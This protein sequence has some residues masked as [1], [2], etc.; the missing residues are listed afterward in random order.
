MQNVAEMAAVPAGEVN[1]ILGDFNVD[2][3]GANAG[4]YNWM[5]NGIYTMELD[6]RVAHAGAVVPARKP[7]CMTHLLPTLDAWP[8]NAVGVV[9]NPQQN[10]YPRYGYMGSAFPNINDSGAIDN[11]FTAYGGGGTGGPAANVTV[12]NRMVGTPYNA[13][14]VTPAGVT[15]ELTGG[16]QYARGGVNPIPLPSL[17]NPPGGVYPPVGGGFPAV[18]PNNFQAWG[19]FGGIHST[20]DHLP[21]I[22]DI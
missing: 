3:F 18:V 16:L 2:A 21:L 19:N 4:A 15:A 8:L 10:V 17:A 12:I 6:P 11:F 7:Y 1:V 20:S 22:I 5:I 9:A 13:L 14:A